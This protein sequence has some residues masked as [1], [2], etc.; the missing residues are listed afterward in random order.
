M[1]E[2]Q[3]QATQN[4]QNFFDLRRTGLDIS[5]L[6][7]VDVSDIICILHPCSPVAFEAASRT[8]DSSPQ[9]V[10]YNGS[11]GHSDGQTGD[12]RERQTFL[13]PGEG[14]NEAVDFALRFSSQTI[15]PALG[16]IFG[17]HPSKC[18]C[19]IAIQN[20]RFISN[21]HFRIYLNPSG[22]LMLEDISTNGTI[23][24]D[25]LLLGRSKESDMPK[26]RMLKTGS[27]I[28]ILAVGQQSHFKL[29]VRIPSRNGHEADYEEKFNAYMHRITTNTPQEY[30]STNPDHPNTTQPIIPPFSAPS[31]RPPTAHGPLIKKEYGM[32]WTGG[33]EY[34]VIGLLGKG[35]FATVF[36]LA[37]KSTGILYAAKE[38]D[39]RKF[40]KNG[41][42]DRKLENELQIMKDLSHPNIVQYVEYHDHDKHLYII[43]EFVPSGDL[44]QLLSSN[45]PLHEVIAKTMAAQILSAL[46][47][48]HDK[49]ITHRDIKPD[50]VLISNANPDYFKVKLSDFGLSKVVKDNDTFLKTFCGT[51][52]YCAP[53]VFP[54]YDTHIEG[55]NRKRA[56][57]NGKKYH[58]YSQSVD[59][60][61]LGAVLWLSLCGQTPFEGVMDATGKGM[62]ERI[63]STPLDITPLQIYGATPAA[64]DLCVHMLQTDPSDRPTPRQC[65]RHTWFSNI[66]KDQILGGEDQE[67]TLRDIS[68]ED[69]E[70]LGHAEADLSQLQID[71]GSYKEEVSF[72]SSELDFS[73][74]RQPKKA[75]YDDCTASGIHEAN[76]RPRQMIATESSQALAQTSPGL[77]RVVSEKA[78]ISSHDTR[79]MQIENEVRRDSLA[80]AELLVRD[81]RMS[82]N[83]SS[84][85]HNDKNGVE[86]DKSEQQYAVP[87]NV[88]IDNGAE[89]KVVQQHASI[90][91]RPQRFDR[92]IDLPLT[93]SFFYD[94]HDPST[95][96][97]DYASLRSGHDFKKNPLMPSSSF[98]AN[99]GMSR[100][101]VIPQSLTNLSPSTTDMPQSTTNSPHVTSSLPQLTT[102]NLD[103]NTNVDQMDLQTPILPHVFQM[104]SNHQSTIHQ[105]GRLVSTPDSFIQLTIPITSRITTWGRA[106][107]CTV[108]YP[109]KDDTRIAKRNLILL[110]DGPGMTEALS[111]NK[112]WTASSEI[113]CWI[114]T[115]SRAGILI[116]GVKLMEKDSHGRK[117]SGKLHHEDVVTIV[118]SQI[119]GLR[120]VV[121]LYRGKGL[122]TREAG[123]GF[124]ITTRKEKS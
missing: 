123:E 112:D 122:K 63:M 94:P 120:F 27:V 47:Y 96:N 121:E 61:S 114:G 17:R 41:I 33:S 46:V 51:L 86:N 13:L 12:P 103:N 82:S 77:G 50:N 69:E 74:G 117:L 100:Q 62:F 109:H 32:H 64:I 67:E 8:A 119:D 90:T 58:S 95:H 39:K 45:G 5:D 104:S 105:H 20:D 36:Q 48:L 87:T 43:M 4:T 49:S 11:K 102:T 91:P 124:H 40:M 23:V 116:N 68:E 10:L 16:F 29:I 73:D 7:I 53:E 75:R 85:P 30:N 80:G 24:D 28:Q 59:I 81:M 111:Q 99:K 56:R 115:E 107:E 19:V 98:N 55:R 15:S 26:T 66:T 65:C 70:D 37:T 88:V 79:S 106:S 101:G 1:P 54:H 108:V 21:V 2:G 57:R 22:V 113:D 83:S 78:A 44:Q 72:G 89:G 97:L 92:R 60:W 84:S 18:D 52:L 9:H 25:Q 118:N 31:S 3:T 71:N 93:A 42:L 6:G 14:R 38:L 76:Q 110:F 35:A 34:N